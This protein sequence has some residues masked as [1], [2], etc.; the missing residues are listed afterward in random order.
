MPYG[1]PAASAF[2]VHL[3]SVSFLEASQIRSRKMNFTFYRRPKI[4]VLGTFDRP[5][6]PAV[7]DLQ[8]LQLM[9]EI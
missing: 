3:T 2:F 9:I 6:P 8:Q 5:L 4:S 7:V 1:A